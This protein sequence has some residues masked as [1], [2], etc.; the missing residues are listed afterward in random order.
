MNDLIIPQHSPHPPLDVSCDRR[1][2]YDASCDDGAFCVFCASCG[3]GSFCRAGGGSPSVLEQQLLAALAARFAALI[4]GRR[5]A[6][7]RQPQNLPK[8][9]L[10]L[11]LEPV[12]P[13]AAVAAAVA[14]AGPSAYQ[15]AWE[16]L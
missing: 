12:P 15:P 13:S 1:A 16:P 3:C 7:F 8:P 2:S 5:L 11:V 14:V 9:G 10:A 4:L 6:Q